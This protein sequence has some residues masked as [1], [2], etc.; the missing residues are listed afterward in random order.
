M[1]RWTRAAGLLAVALITAGL[2]APVAG[3]LATA[4]PIGAPVAPS[5]GGRELLRLEVDS[6]SPRLVTAGTTKVTVTGRITNVGDRRVDDIDA[7]LQRGDPV[8]AD[9]DLWNLPG[10]AT[11][12]ADTPFVEVS[13]SLDPGDSVELSLDAALRGPDSLD[14]STPG[15]YPLLVNVNGEPDFGGQARLAAVSLP[16]PVLEVDGAPAVRPRDDPPAMTVIWPILDTEPRRL[17]VS[18]EDG[19]PVLGDD[20]L[21]ESV[22]AGGRLFG[23]VNSAATA[24]AS[25]GE[26]ATSLCFALDPDLLSTVSDMAKGYYVRDENGRLVAGGGDEAAADWLTRVAELTRGRCV[27]SVPF[28]DAD[29]V[30]LS[31]SG[32]VDLA[33]VALASSSTVA[34]LLAP[35]QPVAGLFWP[36][37]GSFDKRTVVDLAAIGPTTV[38]AD[39]AHLQKVS[40][41]APYSVTGTTQTAYPVRAL[42]TDPLL[43]SSLNVAAP[44]SGGDRSLQRGLAALTFRALFDQKAAGAQVLVAPPRR[45]TASTSELTGYLDLAQRLLDGGYVEPASLQ[46]QAAAPSAGTAGGL[47]YSPQD[48]AREVPAS[49]SAQVARLNTTRRDLLDAMSGDNTSDVDPNTLLAPLQNGLLRATS[50]AW[51]G[52]PRAAGDAVEEVREQLDTLRARVTV[53]NPDRPLQ[54]ASG[55]SP[56]PVSVHNELPVG[57][58]V[59]VRVSAPPGLNIE[60]IQDVPVPPHHTRNAYVP[61]EVTRAGRFKVEVSLT[62]PG[63][64]PLGE[65]ARLELSSTSYGVITVAITGTAGGVLVILVAFRIFRR[66]RGARTAAR[67]DG[68]ADGTVDG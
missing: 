18:R 40:G 66:I 36:A 19:R 24:T 41:A 43:S 48:S 54:M 63:G 9:G 11:D 38:I 16:L 25:N 45:W 26:L 67:K 64:T 1:T 28:A 13:E 15:V 65:D 27:M 4:D 34:E 68:P 32:A 3:P 31:R 8:R 2:A 58:T 12:T 17:P 21:A 10:R 47:T 55:D 30:A 33:T 61:A 6:L 5:G 59:R 37:G 42:A 50:T 51:R 46:A 62:T 57:I 29:L 49:V 23:L 56:I 39:P 52:D 20:Q 44:R 14:V 60:P 7:K 35:V 22:S 53:T